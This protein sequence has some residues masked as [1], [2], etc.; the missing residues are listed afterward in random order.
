MRLI[1]VLLCVGIWPARAREAPGDDAPR[2]A[3]TA[4][5]E[6]FERQIRPLLSKKCFSCHGP[7][8]QKSELRLDSSAAM[9][10]GGLTGPAVVPGKPDESLLIE[11]IRYEE[12]LK[13]PPKAKLDPTQIEA[14]VQWVERGAHWPN[15]TRPSPTPEADA[16]GEDIIRSRSGHW[17]FQPL[18]AVSPPSVDN[19]GWADSP[20][21]RFVLA[22][23]ERRELTAAPQAD[24]RTL[25]R[26]LSF[27]VLGL[28]PTPEEVGSFVADP[29]PDAYERLVDRMLASPRHG[30]R[31]ARHWLDLARY[32]ETSGH[33]FDY[34]IPNAYRYRDYV[35]RAFNDDLTYDQF[36]TEHLAG[37]LLDNPRR[38]PLTGQN[39]SIVG[40]GF[41]LLG[42]GTH[43]PVDI[44]EEQL[45]RIDNQI[46]VLG[47]TL[48]GLTIACARC[49]D[50]KFDPIRARDYYAL[51]GYFKSA[52][53]QQAW[54]SDTDD[55]VKVART[56]REI[57]RRVARLLELPTLATPS[58]A[59]SANDTGLFED[60][61][62]T[63]YRE[64]FPSGAAFGDA[65]SRPGDA[66]I[67]PDGR[68]ELVPPG[69]AHSGLASDRLHG[70]L[71]SRTFTIG[72]PFIHVLAAGRLGRVQVV[73]DGFE[74]IRDPIYGGL[75][76][77][78]ESA[79]AY[80]WHAI[81]V[82]AWLGHRAYIELADGGI[83]DYTGGQTGLSP[84]DGF[85]AVD[86]IRMKGTASLDS[87]TIVSTT[88]QPRQ[89]LRDAAILP[90]LERLLA[91]LQELSDLLAPPALS[92]ALADGTG[93]DEY[94]LMRGNPKTPGEIAPRRFLEVIVGD[95][96]ASGSIENSGRLELARQLLDPANPL[97]ARV[98]VNR[99]WLHYFGRGLVSTPDDFGHMG[100]PPTHPELLDWLA[101]ELIH[102]GWSLKHI[103]R[104]IVT[105]RAYSMSSIP[106]PKNVERDPE[107]RWL[108][109]ANVHRLEAEPL[110]DAM[111][112]VAGC[113]EQ[114]LYGPSI[115]PHLT[116]F[117]QGRGRPAASGPLDGN[118]RRSL[119]I[120]IR[121]NFVPPLFAAFDYPPPVSTMGR[122]NIS[123]V[124]AQAL[125]LLNDPFVL[126]M[127]R[128][129]AAN[130]CRAPERPPLQRIERMYLSAFGRHP[131]VDE[132]SAALGFL[133]STPTGASLQSWAD[134]AQVLFN[135]KEFLFIP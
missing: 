77:R 55:A 96:A 100:Q 97:P 17:S 8:Q 90:E 37:D 122:R 70:V 78:V 46:D 11:A 107:N 135:H 20:I 93:E 95:T 105:S 88:I 27:D 91:R 126:E 74:K 124:P 103:H 21:D 50:H 49:H 57:V 14:L 110:R 73:I 19:P 118:N 132:R 119:Y 79:D 59:T 7:E 48:L 125:T 127:S 111:L 32:A 114:T 56:L 44:R 41:F 28:P 62:Q 89:A 92:L 15:D 72:H 2:A 1:V 53:H 133:E 112:A 24:R 33:E 26:R 52:R 71:R 120:N 68:V 121:R 67:L 116:E 63:D 80:K 45:R 84:D 94:V 42:E 102:G 36:I 34:D 85:L 6:F 30:E 58:S 99:I 29:R 23:L 115:L 117:Q 47:K 22:Q 5:I 60:F 18:R 64:W 4:D 82:S 16:P 61:S 83:T 76:A 123:N 104:L 10:A 12:M 39:E 65:P 134:L 9:R 81:D 25:I 113:L 109:R 35:V 106:D 98:V 51:A 31:W 129:W 69:V 3:T 13:M 87:S 43:S 101:R 108:H 40:T 54:L 131:T 86:E 66:R 128:R 75:I 130:V 38:D